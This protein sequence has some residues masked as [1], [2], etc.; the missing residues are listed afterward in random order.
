MKW[1]LNALI[2]WISETRVARR[3]GPHFKCLIVLGCNISDSAGIQN[4]FQITI[5]DKGDEAMTYEAMVV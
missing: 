4:T 2:L 3:F 1:G 5:F